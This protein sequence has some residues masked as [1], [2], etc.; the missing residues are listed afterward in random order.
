MASDSKPTSKELVL[1]T[2]ISSQFSELR[3]RTN[4][5]PLKPMKFY[6]PDDDDSVSCAFAL[7]RHAISTANGSEEALLSGYF[8]ALCAVFPDLTVVAKKM[9]ENLGYQAEEIMVPSQADRMNIEIPQSDDLRLEALKFVHMCFLPFQRIFGHE[10]AALWDKV[11]ANCGIK[12]KHSFSTT[13][14]CSEADIKAISEAL[15]LSCHSAELKSG[16]APSL[17]ALAA[18]NTPL[19]HV[20]ATA[21]EM[22]INMSRGYINHMYD[23]EL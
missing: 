17:R 5:V 13:K 9:M 12:L 18:T 16:I 21:A 15:M 23:V 4:L 1:S 22:N 7:G 8:S 14:L 3:I 2:P 11:A 19:A 10:V 6:V 20:L